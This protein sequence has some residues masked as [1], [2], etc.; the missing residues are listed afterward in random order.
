MLLKL[1]SFGKQ[2][3]HHLEIVFADC[4]LKMLLVIVLDLTKWKDRTQ[5]YF[6]MSR[7][8]ITA[9]VLHTSPFSWV[10]L[11]ENEHIMTELL[12]QW[13]HLLPQYDPVHD[14]LLVGWH[15]G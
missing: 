1:M 7:T 10:Q 8:S 6:D 12:F 14:F 2:D 15:I 5:H 13:Q 9:I 4:N 3:D 11:K